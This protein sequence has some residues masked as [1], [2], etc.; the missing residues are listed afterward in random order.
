MSKKKI[1]VAPLFFV[2][3][4]KSKVLRTIFFARTLFFFWPQYFKFRV[5]LILNLNHQL[6]IYFALTTENWHRKPWHDKQR[7]RHNIQLKYWYVMCGTTTISGSLLHC[8]SIRRFCHIIISDWSLPQYLLFI[9][10][11]WRSIIDTNPPAPCRKGWHYILKRET[12]WNRFYC[13]LHGNSS[14]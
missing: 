11:F 4:N 9:S 14:S 12:A 10:Y 2:W 3:E 8:S 5:N 13:Y 1:G 7:S 6:L